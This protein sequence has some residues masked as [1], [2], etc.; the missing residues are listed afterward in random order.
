M[1][2]DPLLPATGAAVSDAPLKEAVIRAQRRYGLKP[3]GVSA[4]HARPT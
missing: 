2:E 1:A 4:P 3:D